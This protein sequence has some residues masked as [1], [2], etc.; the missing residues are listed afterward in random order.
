M[1]SDDI[2][3]RLRNHGKHWSQGHEGKTD[4]ERGLC[5]Q[6]QAADEIQRL[7]NKLRLT[8]RAYDMAVFGESDIDENGVLRDD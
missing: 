7:R 5:S 6:C 2:V 8:Q 3:T 1:V 4:C